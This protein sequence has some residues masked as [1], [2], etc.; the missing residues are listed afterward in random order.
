MKGEREIMGNKRAAVRRVLAGL[1]VLLV[2]TLMAGC[3]RPAAET[4]PPG[5]EQDPVQAAIIFSIV[6]PARAGGWDR[7]DWAGILALREE[8]GWEVTVAEGVPYGQVAATAAG[9]A[10]AGYD[11]VI[12]PDAGMT[13]AWHEVS[14]KYPKTWFV[15]M[16]MAEQLPASPRVAAWSPDL[17]AYG[18]MLGVAAAK[19]SQTGTIGLLGG[20]PVP[21]IAY[22]FSGAVEAARFVRPDIRVLTNFVGDWVDVTAHREI[23][24]LQVREGADVVFALTGPGILGSYEAAI[25]GNARVIGHAWDLHED[26]PDAI[27]TSMVLDKPRMYRDLARQFEADMLEKKI[28]DVGVEYFK[29][30]DFRGAIPQATVDEINE[31]VEKLRGG[32]LPVPKVVHSIED[33][34]KR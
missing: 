6:N 22:L 30:A 5:P 19:S 28:V 3:P 8:F 7:A 24:A 31:L 29:L 25:A 23:T 1:S 14:P 2:M 32:E 18:Q 20:V 15:M 13:D 16:S 17:Y 12:F 4:P 10:E 11:I 27:L 21:V 9:F 34:L 26:A 33:L